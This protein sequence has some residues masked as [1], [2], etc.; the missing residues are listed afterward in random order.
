MTPSLCSL[1]QFLIRRRTVIIII[2]NINI[3]D[4][5]IIFVISGSVLKQQAEFIN[6]IRSQPDYYYYVY[7]LLNFI[8]DGMFHNLSPF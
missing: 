1:D 3:R 7:I 8:S 2:I 5:Y 6:P 4:R